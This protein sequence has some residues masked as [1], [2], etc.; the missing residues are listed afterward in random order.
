MPGNWKSPPTGWRATCLIV[1]WPGVKV[2]S[3]WA[4]RSAALVWAVLG[5]L[6]A[7]AAFLILDPAYPPERLAEYVRQARPKGLLSISDAELPGEGRV[8]L[9]PWVDTIPTGTGSALGIGEALDSQPDTLPEVVLTAGDLAY[10][11]FTSGSTGRP[12]GVRGL[13]GSLSHFLPWMTESFGL[14]AED[15]FSM[16]SGLAFDPLQREIFT[17]LWVGARIR[18]PGPDLLDGIGRLADWLIR[19]AITPAHAIRR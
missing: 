9:V 5:I 3:I 18:I 1:E 12:K 15:R 19:D 16:L 4:S 10:A 8:D 2:I 13:H 17:P 14:R 7:G 11:T 6:K